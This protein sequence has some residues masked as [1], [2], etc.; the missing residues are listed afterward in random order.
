MGSSPSIVNIGTGFGGIGRAPE[1]TWAGHD[2]LVPA[3]RAECEE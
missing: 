1:R 3:A 2:R